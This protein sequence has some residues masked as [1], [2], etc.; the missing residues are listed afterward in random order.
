MNQPNRVVAIFMGTQHVP[1]GC[2]IYRITMPFYYLEQHGWKTEYVYFND[3]WQYCQKNGAHAWGKFVLDHDLFVF[4]RLYVPDDEARMVLRGLFETLRLTNRRVIYETDDDYT[5]IHRQVV[6]GD[7]ISPAIFSDAVT[8]TTPL[9][10]NT[11]KR[12]TKRPVHVLPNCISPHDFCEGNAPARN[13]AMEGKL[14]IA[15]TGSQTHEKD[16]RVLERIIPRILDEYPQAHFLTMGYTPDYLKGLSRHIVVPPAPYHTYAQIL[17]GCDIIL[18]PVVPD[19]GF[20]LGKSQIKAVEGMAAQRLLPSGI[21]AGA[22][23]IATRNPVYELAIK[24]GK[25]GLLTEHTSEAWYQSIKQLLE[26]ESL[27]HSLQVNGYGYVYKHLD[28]T[29]EWRQWA[30]VYRKVLDAPANTLS[31]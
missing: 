1:G 3:L 21:S 5:N 25:T 30:R 29:R 7:A 8:V 24:H 6:T 15:L 11:M 20:N 19:D 4:P 10:A 17:R 27:R 26:D 13:P 14:I 2:E 9:L 16:W 28:I 18:A 12:F 23:V 22:A 31:F